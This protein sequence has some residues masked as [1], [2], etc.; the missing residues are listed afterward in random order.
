MNS[1]TLLTS[2]CCLD[3][4][5]LYKREKPYEMRFYPPGNFPRKNLH[6]STYHDIPVEDVRNQEKDLSIDK[7]GFRLMQINVSMNLE[8]FSSRE[9]IRSQYLPQ[10]AKSLK[11]CLGASRVQVHDYLVS[12]IDPMLDVILLNH[13]FRYAR[14]MNH[15]P[16]QLGNRMIGS[17]QQL[18]FTLV[19]TTSIQ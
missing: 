18:S 1:K 7:N 3:K 8:D 9:A 19:I 14:V 11:E 12:P 6:I 10:V 15:S 2:I 4:L 5:E 17:S 13:V 16:Y